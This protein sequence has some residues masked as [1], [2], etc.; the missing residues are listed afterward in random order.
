M[1]K[2]TLPP[3]RRIPGPI[4]PPVPTLLRP[5]IAAQLPMTGVGNLA[6]GIAGVMNEVGT[7]K[8]GGYN[9][10]H[11]YHYARLED[12]LEALTPLM[13]RH[14]VVVIQNEVERSVVEN[15]V[16]VTYEFSILH[17]SGEVWPERPRFTGMS[18][19]RD[20]KGGFDDKAVN[21]CHSAARKYFLLSLFQVPSGDF[22]DSDAGAPRPERQEI[23]QPVP[24]PAPRKPEPVAAPPLSVEGA[25]DNKPHRIVVKGAEAWAEA[26][27]K[28][29]GRAKSTEEVT[30][31][32]VLN[33]TNLDNLNN[34][35]PEIYTRLYAAAENRLRGFQALDPMYDPETGEVGDPT[36]LQ[37]P[38]PREDAQVAV[39]W[40]AQ[41]LS[42]FNTYEAAEVFWNSV[43]APRETAFNAVDFDVLLSEW[44][45]TEARLAGT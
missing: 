34:N 37:M 20:S 30:Q 6:K 2:P 7:I 5:S 44:R 16:M 26:Y 9:K 27:I 4:A 39:N 42:E 15:K 31:W 45:R 21:K 38:E 12:L 1:D 18:G 11:N 29:I 10:F 17:T 24:G 14:G 13:G 36:P 40:V 22:D 41:H 43:V 32:D 28:A 8:K 25:D 19:G 35:Y 33:A 23:R 3:P